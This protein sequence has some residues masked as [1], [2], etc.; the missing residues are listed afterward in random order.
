[1]TTR[2]ARARK[3]VYSLSDL[4][5]VDFSDLIL[6]N[7][8]GW[9]CLS[10]SVLPDEVKYPEVANLAQQVGDVLSNV[11]YHHD[12]KFSVFCFSRTAT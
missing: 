5:I 10:V 7:G 12:M 4:Q 8:V 2:T 6:S 9:Y 11:L 1:M 3:N